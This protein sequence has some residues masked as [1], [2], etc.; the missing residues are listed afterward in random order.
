MSD[1]S[2]RTLAVKFE[3]KVDPSLEQS[4]KQVQ[5][6]VKETAKGV[7]DTAKQ[8]SDR[9]MAIATGIGTAIGNIAANGLMVVGEKAKEFLSGAI[10]AASDLNEAINIT[11]SIFGESAA[12]MDG[13][14]QNSATSIGMSEAAARSASANIGGL[15]QNM[16]LG[17]D[18]SVQWSESLLTLSADMGSAFNKEP[19]EAIEAIG[20][21][22]RGES[23]PLRAF[24]VMLSDSAIQAEAMRMG[25]VK[26]AVDMDKVS[27]AQKRAEVAQMNYT[28]AVK[29]H[30]E[31]S[32]EATAAAATLQAAEGNLNKVMEGSKQP[33]TNQQKALASLSLIK[34]Q[35]SAI[36]GDFAKTSGEEAN[37][38]R[39]VAAQV[40][41]LQ[42]KIGT[43][44]LPAKKELL[45]I[46][47]T[48]LIPAFSKFVDGLKGA[49]EWIQKNQGWLAPLGVAVG[50]LASGYVA[51]A[52]AQAASNAQAAIAAAGGIV[53]FIKAW[54]TQQAFL[55]VVLAANPIGLVVTAIAALAA[56]LIYAYN[57]N[58]DFRRGVD[59]G[60]RAI[61]E[62]GKWLWN[63]ALAPMIR[64]I[65]NGFATIVDG[66]G[67]MLQALGKIPGFG[68][69]KTAGDAM[70]GAAEQARGLAKS[71]SDIKDKTV[72]VS[73]KYTASGDMQFGNG[74]KASINATGGIF[75]RG[76]QQV[77]FAGGGVMPGYTPGK[78][79][80]Q[81]YAPNFGF[82]GLSGGEAILRPEATRVLGPEWV[83]GVNDAAMGGG[84]AG[85]RQYL[86]GFD[87]G[88]VFG[89]AGR[90]G[91]WIDRGADVDA[92]L[93]RAIDKL[94][95]ALNR[96]APAPVNVG[97]IHV[98][99]DEDME[100][101][102]RFVAMVERKKR[103]GTKGA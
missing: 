101:L 48:Q 7:E 80:Y 60:F 10:P 45:R 30:G 25:L 37:A 8:T 49:G 38:S 18:E 44:L 16:G 91:E 83:D 54:A 57:T 93:V 88:G 100:T 66:I 65:V 84:E 77:A 6:K 75:G 22:L 35:T 34:K 41:D 102:K 9:S 71:I 98:S 51:L 39:I 3:G 2:S 4:S 63:N 50:V 36:N 19:A 103:A 24:N 5:E 15:L 26:N 53:N 42:A 85:V 92:A 67:A 31:G 52:A 23:E 12:K 79:I 58:E 81:F 17:R 55:N 87:S 11:S 86:V 21:G 69:A 64:F 90:S 1:A 82:L 46:T 76:S 43:Q 14:F 13:F 68:W 72:N 96:P 20:A 97:D 62:A 78:D 99:D 59:G 61:G 95:E 74:M 33:L 28:A 89:Q 47:S 27:V 56:G 70:R 40:T 29:K 73:V 94:T 32:K